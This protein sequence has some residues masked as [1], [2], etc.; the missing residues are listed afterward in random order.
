[1]NK[2]EV[3]ELKL[4][5]PIHPRLCAP[6]IILPLDMTPPENKIY[7]LACLNSLLNEVGINLSLKH[8]EMDN[9]SCDMLCININSDTFIQKTNRNA[10]RKADVNKHGNYTEC[11]VAEFKT[12]I[13]TMKHKDII[14]YLNCPRAT[15]YRI[16]KNLRE[17]D[18]WDDNVLSIW[19]YTI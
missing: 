12:M 13:D 14:K 11:S 8:K 3:N 17:R 15:F 19:Y 6:Y 10:G 16:L 4:D 9:Y 18:D 5:K 7:D 2:E 1:M